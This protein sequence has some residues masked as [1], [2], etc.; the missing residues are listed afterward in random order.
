MMQKDLAYL[1][2]MVAKHLLGSW[3][4]VFNILLTANLTPSGRWGYQGEIR[5]VSCGYVL[6]EDQ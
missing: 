3:G 6:Q 2:G 1:V 5:T 4:D